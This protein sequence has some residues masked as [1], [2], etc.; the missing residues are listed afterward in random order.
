[1]FGIFPEPS[2]IAD[3]DVEPMPYL[4][5][6]TIHP[7]VLADRLAVFAVTAQRIADLMAITPDEQVQGVKLFDF[8]VSTEIESDEP[9]EMIEIDEIDSS[10]GKRKQTEEDVR[11]VKRRKQ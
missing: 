1:M 8:L 7:Q 11:E 3:Q 4:E 9:D 10:L 2:I 6:Q 5:A